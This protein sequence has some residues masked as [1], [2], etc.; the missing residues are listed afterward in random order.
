MNK[1]KI[2]KSFLLSMLLY[3]VFLFGLNAQTAIPITGSEATGNNGTVS[4][5]MGQ[6]IYTQNTGTNGYL[7][8]G[9]HQ[10]F[11]ISVLSGI[12]DIHNVDLIL[13]VFPNPTTDKLVLYVQDNYN[14]VNLHYNLY[15]LNGVLLISEKIQSNQTIISLYKHIPSTYFIKVLKS[16]DGVQSQVLKVFKIIKK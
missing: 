13:T 9:V 16:K 7:L 4:Y 2:H 12:K 14:V 6:L 8:Y 11:E 10:P 1:G 15:D 5:T 3:F